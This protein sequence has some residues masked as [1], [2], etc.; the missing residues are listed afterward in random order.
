MLDMAESVL[1]SL[2]QEY[3]TKTNKFH[4]IQ[5]VEKSLAY[6]YFLFKNKKYFL[7]CH[8]F[9]Q[10]PFLTIKNAL[11]FTGSMIEIIQN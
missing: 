3:R 1:E 10:Y 6:F 5:Q 9:K 11:K 2:T 8:Y 7:F 4:N